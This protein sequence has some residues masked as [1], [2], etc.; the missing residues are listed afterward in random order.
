[1]NNNNIGWL[2]FGGYKNILPSMLTILPPSSTQAILLTSLSIYS[3]IPLKAIQYYMI[4]IHTEL[5]VAKIKYSE[6]PFERPPPLKRPLV[7]VNLNIN[8]LIFTPDERPPLS[9]GHFS[10]AKGVASQEGFH[11][12]VFHALCEEGNIFLILPGQYFFN[13]ARTLCDQSFNIDLRLRYV[14][15]IHSS[16]NRAMPR[17]PKLLLLRPT[18][19]R[20][21][22]MTKWQPAVTHDR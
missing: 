9:K 7:N 15:G 10:D 22:A 11:C 4:I 2:F 12:S 21:R 3:C 16:E 18:S 13:I 5:L 14:V 17:P 6:T 1:M 8:V 19:I 20:F